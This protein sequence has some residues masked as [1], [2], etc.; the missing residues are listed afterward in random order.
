MEVAKC[1]LTVGIIIGAH[2]MCHMDVVCRKSFSVWGPAT[3]IITWTLSDQ[4]EGPQC[5]ISALRSYVANLSYYIIN[6]LGRWSFKCKSVAFILYA[7][8][9]NTDT[10]PQMDAFCVH[11]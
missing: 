1:R 4:K 3:S 7:D 2:N 5:L 11:I 8:R 10:M 9:F 6:T